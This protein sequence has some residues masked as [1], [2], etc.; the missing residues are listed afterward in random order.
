M[1]NNALGRDFGVT[2][3]CASAPADP[4]GSMQSPY[5]F[6]A[7]LADKRIIGTLTGLTLY[8]AQQALRTLYDVARERAVADLEAAH[9]AVVGAKP[10]RPGWMP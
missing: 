8:E 1:S 2:I 4:N 7:E 6:T 9:A 5:L 10:A 3:R